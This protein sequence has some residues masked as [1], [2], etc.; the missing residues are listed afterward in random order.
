MYKP[1]PVKPRKPYPLR[2]FSCET[3]A[4]I[5]NVANIYNIPDQNRTSYEWKISDYPNNRP[6][7]NKFKGQ[8]VFCLVDFDQKSDA[9]SVCKENCQTPDKECPSFCLCRW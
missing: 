5:F 3:F 1:N 4:P 9:C 8:G 7:L 2:L 6:D